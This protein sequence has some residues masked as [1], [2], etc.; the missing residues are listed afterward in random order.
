MK[1]AGA[2]FRAAA[3]YA[4]G[5]TLE[6]AIAG[7]GLLSPIKRTI[8]KVRLYLYG[9]CIVGPYTILLCMTRGNITSSGVYIKP[10]F[11]LQAMYLQMFEEMA[12]TL[13]KY[14]S[15]GEICMTPLQVCI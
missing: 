10:Y 3:A 13:A 12:K 4:N 15:N 5:D 2:I 8:E 11:F 9:F 6:D 7:A 14:M 1:P